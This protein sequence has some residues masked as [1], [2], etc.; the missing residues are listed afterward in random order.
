MKK[1]IVT[2]WILLMLAFAGRAQ[3]F[4]IPLQSNPALKPAPGQYVQP[5]QKSGTALELPFKDD[6]SHPGMHPDESKWQDKWV[7]INNS[8]GPLPP[9]VGMA[10]FDALDD[11][12]A[13]YTWAN[14]TPFLADFLTSHP[15]RLDSIISGVPAALQV[16]DSVYMSFFY[17]PQGF[18]NSPEGADSLLLEF[19]NPASSEWDKVWGAKGT[20]YEEFFAEY[21][22]SFKIVMIPILNPDYF[23]PEF[24]FRFKNY[25]SIV[26]NSFPSWQ[27]N[28]D[29]WNIDYVY[30]NYNRNRADTTFDDIAFVSPP[31]SILK[32]Y[33][34]MPARQ[35]NNSELKTAFGLKI[36]NLSAALN[37]ISYRYDVNEVSGPYSYTK[38]GGDYDILPYITSGY[39]TWPFH[40]NP[41]VDFTLPAITGDSTAF[42]ITH[43]LGI[44]GWTDQLLSN[45][46]MTFRQEF[47]NY[48][49]YD[50]GSAEQ[51]YGLAGVGSRLAYKF[52][53]NQTDTLG[54]VKMFF[55]Q[56]LLPPTSRYFYVVVWSSLSPET[57]IYKSKRTRPFTGDSL[58]AFHTY[59]I[60]DTTLVLSGTF[61]VG[62]Q[63]ITDEVL[64]IGFDKSVNSQDKIFFNTEGSWQNTVFEGS[65]MMRPVLGTGGQAK[66]L[67]V[68]E[69]DIK[70]YPNPV[71]RGSTG[72]FL[73]IDLPERY[74]TL[75]P[76]N[77]MT[78]EI[79]TNLGKKILEMPYAPSIP[80]AHLQN[81]FYVLRLN[82]YATSES[83]RFTFVVA[84]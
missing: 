32:N 65:L 16:S 66:R 61:Y 68:P 57:I 50:D 60:S 24:Q 47:Y 8:F 56:T 27:S 14:P 21:G 73:Y 10:T 77:K 72:D 33:T 42:D 81:G 36:S 53:L 69:T 54:G 76:G 11:T 22:V 52:T 34:Q 43:T 26:N 55:N 49:A 83:F 41:A 80:M 19:Y 48:Y 70:I 20:T 3:E 39:H 45:N 17:Q 31:E 46:V 64:N 23:S 9:T 35:F 62:W 38:P 37:N 18:G 75:D 82:S 30:L 44:N 40:S 29:Q 5:V 15:I 7:F 58:N 63:Q 78:V 6:F 25:A 71:G 74:M 2:S 13:L 1:A 84:R 4:L 51:G 79:F 59:F 67:I 12:G 28:M